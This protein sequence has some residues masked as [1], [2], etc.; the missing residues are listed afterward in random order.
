MVV[1]Q[2]AWLDEAKAR[3][4]VGA[5][6]AVAGAVTAAFEDELHWYAVTVVV[7]DRVPARMHC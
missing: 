6:V 1:V 3:A 5:V 7:P 4:A 2:S